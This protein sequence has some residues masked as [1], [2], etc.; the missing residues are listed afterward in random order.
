MYFFFPLFHFHV[1]DCSTQLFFFFFLV[2]CRNPFG[3]FPSTLNHFWPWKPI[4]SWASS[5]VWPESWGR[6]FST[7]TPLSWDHIWSTAYS[8]GAPS[9]W[10]TQTV[11][12]GPEESLKDDKELKQLLYEDMKAEW[13][14]WVIFFCKKDR[15]IFFTSPN[16]DRTRGISFKLK[17]GRFR[18]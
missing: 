14:S 1:S 5:K 4:I 8:S 12:V 16:E 3:F 13:E 18:L 17:G 15:Y 7:S 10:N 9:I 11:G 2:H 6:L